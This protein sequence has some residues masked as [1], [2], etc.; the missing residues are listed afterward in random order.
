VQ[1]GG[2][3]GMIHAGVTERLRSGNISRRE[4]KKEFENACG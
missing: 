2:S 1:E 4:R 3:L